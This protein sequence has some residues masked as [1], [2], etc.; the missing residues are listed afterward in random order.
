MGQHGSIAVV[1]RFHRTLKELLRL[2]TIPEDQTTS[3]RELGLI[4]DWYNEHRPHET[5]DGKTPN[6]VHYS[7]PAASE[8]PRSEPRGS[9]RRCRLLSHTCAGY[10]G[11]RVDMATAGLCCKCEYGEPC[12]G[13]TCVMMMLSPWGG[14]PEIAFNVTAGRVCL[15]TAFRWEPSGPNTVLKPRCGPT[16][17]ETLSVRKESLRCLD[18]SGYR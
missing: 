18:I 14:T 5:L 3:E 12:L 6:E 2:T 8:R 9:R 4:T 1:E 10:L 11:F 13:K 16:T 15:A 7:R 17:H